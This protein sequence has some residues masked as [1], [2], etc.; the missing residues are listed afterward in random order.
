MVLNGLESL[1]AL[2]AGSES[3]VDVS[4]EILFT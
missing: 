3:K 4:R 2:Q 1:I